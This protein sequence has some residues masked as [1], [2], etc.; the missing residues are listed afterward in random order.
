MSLFFMWTEA[1]QYSPAIQPFLIIGTVLAIVI[2]WSRTEN[3]WV[4]ALAGYFGWFYIAYYL[5]LKQWQKL[6]AWLSHKA[7]VRKS[8]IR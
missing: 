1:N 8:A 7:D 5:I 6:D 3:V 4:S 2:C